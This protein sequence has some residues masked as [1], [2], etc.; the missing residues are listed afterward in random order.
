MNFNQLITQLQSLDGS[1]K[2]HVAQSA[3]I[4]L[5][6]RNWLVGA[7]IIE[8]EQNGEERAKYGTQLIQKVAKSLKLKG[9]HSTNL[10]LCRRFFLE[11]PSIPPLSAILG[12]KNLISSSK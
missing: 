9:L 4:G 11:Y 2:Q 12:S 1:L 5:T 10:E 6:L 7:Y 8:F 3:N